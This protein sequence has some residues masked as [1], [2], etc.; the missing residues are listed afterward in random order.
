MVPALS[1]PHWLSFPG[2][3]WTQCSF[4]RYLGP[5]CSSGLVHSIVFGM[6]RHRGQGNIN[7]AFLGPTWVWHM[8]TLQIILVSLPQSCSK[9]PLHIENSVV[10]V[11]GSLEH[12]EPH[13]CHCFFHDLQKLPSLYF[14]LRKHFSVWEI[15]CALFWPSCTTPGGFIHTRKTY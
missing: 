5:V 10:S 6:I 14:H 4:L 13:K 11:S 12:Q 2:Q 7:F 3:G 9:P 8:V 1:S 15:K